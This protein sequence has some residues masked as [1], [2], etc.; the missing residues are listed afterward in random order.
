[1]ELEIEKSELRNDF[2]EEQAKK[3]SEG[4]I[5]MGLLSVSLTDEKYFFFY[6]NEFF[7]SKEFFAKKKFL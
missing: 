3:F 5:L 4:W 6:K 1:L 7:H 2:E